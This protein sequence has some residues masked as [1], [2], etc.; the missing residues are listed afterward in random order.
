MR[1]WLTILVFV[2][3]LAVPAFAQSSNSSSTTTTTTQQ[4]QP[5]QTTQSDSSRSTSTTTTTQKSSTPVERTTG[6][7]PLYLALGAV[8]L[9]TIIAIALLAARSRR[10]RDTV[11]VRESKTVI[12]E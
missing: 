2:M 5:A 7:D 3:A 11:A 12:R 9:I 8:A 1:R 10:G 6:I 4:A